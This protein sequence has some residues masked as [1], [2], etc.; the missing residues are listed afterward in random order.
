[1]QLSRFY[2]T[3]VAVFEPPSSPSSLEG[4]PDYV[5]SRFQVGP[6]RY[7]VVFDD[8]NGSGEYFMMYGLDDIEGTDEEFRVWLSHSLRREITLAQAHQMRRHALD[9]PM[10]LIQLGN[11]F[12]VLGRLV[13]T[14]Q[15]FIGQ[16]QPEAIRFTAEGT[17]IG[18]YKK[19]IKRFFSQ[20]DVHIKET[21][22]G[23]AFQIKFK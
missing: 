21:G 23:A 14:I 7:T 16:H 9:F 2:K 5:T 22:G 1:M 17:H 15:D 6:V 10:D 4:G 8:E 13:A 19:M 11:S 12:Q 18:V 20:Q 3:L